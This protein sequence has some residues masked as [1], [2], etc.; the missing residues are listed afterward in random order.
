MA[1]VLNKSDSAGNTEEEET[2]DT[3]YEIQHWD[4]LDLDSNLLLF[5]CPYTF[6]KQLATKK[7]KDRKKILFSPATALP[8]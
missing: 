6:T 1:T 2:Y 4:E 3:S 7:K 5:F 8:P